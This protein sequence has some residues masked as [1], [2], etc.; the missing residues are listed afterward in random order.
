MRFMSA[1]EIVE[2]THGGLGLLESGGRRLRSGATGLPT[3]VFL[4]FP[5]AVPPDP[6]SPCSTPC[7]RA[8]SLRVIK[9]GS[10]A[11]DP[12]PRA[13]RVVLRSPPGEFDL[14]I[15]KLSRGR[16]EFVAR[17]SR[18]ETYPLRPIV[19]PREGAKRNGFRVFS[20]CRMHAQASGEIL[21]RQKAFRRVHPSRA[22]PHI[23]RS[24]EKMRLCVRRRLI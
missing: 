21:P 16:I 10:D 3:R 4:S 23:D 20:A 6:R 19:S 8:P 22:R 18:R 24:R 15:A 17:G 7:D 14:E 11:F 9:K 2:R 5:E 1:G 13:V 12:C